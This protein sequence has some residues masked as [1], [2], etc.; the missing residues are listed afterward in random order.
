MKMRKNRYTPAIPAGYNAIIESDGRVR[1]VREPESVYKA[2]RKTAL[3][4]T[5]K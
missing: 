2:A 3:E 4:N 5:D 1:L